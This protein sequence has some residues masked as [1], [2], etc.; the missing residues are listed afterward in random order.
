MGADRVLKPRQGGLAGQV[1]VVGQ[2][3]REQFED[4]IATE[5]VVIVLIFV[6]GENSV[7]ATSDHLQERMIGSASHLVQLSRERRR[8]AHLFIELPKQQQSRVGGE[9]LLNRF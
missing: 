5:R 3:I 6:A 9:M 8:Q 1:V 7:D 4:G 2:A